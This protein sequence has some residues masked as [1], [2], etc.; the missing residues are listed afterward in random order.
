MII[1][2]QTIIDATAEAEAYRIQ[3]S[4]FLPKSTRDSYSPQH[5]IRSNDRMPEQLSPRTT[6]PHLSRRLR[7]KR[8]FGGESP[9]RTPIDT[10][11]ETNASETSSGDGYFCS[12]VTPVS[13][14]SLSQPRDWRPQN[15]ISHSANSSI[16]ISPQYKSPNPLLSAIPRSTGLLDVNMSMPGT[17]RGKRRAEEVEADDEYDGEESST[18][19]TDDKMSSDEKDSDKEME[20][21]GGAEKKAAW[22]LMKL[23]VKDGECAAEALKQMFDG[24]RIKRVR[25]TSM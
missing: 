5:S 13:A 16:N 15:A 24:P 1:D 25:A 8:A 18:S 12:P 23:S 3:Y 11:V 4:G 20:D 17:W 10:D 2:Q 9:Y 19:V 14:M 21:V 7:L 6:P 22:L